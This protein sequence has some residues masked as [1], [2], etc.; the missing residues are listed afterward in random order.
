[1]DINNPKIDQDTYS[2]FKKRAQDLNFD[3]T[4]IVPMGTTVLQCS[5]FNPSTVTPVCGDVGLTVDEA[6]S[7]FDNNLTQ[8]ENG[9]RQEWMPKIEIIKE[10]Y[11]EFEYEFL[12][13]TGM[14]VRKNKNILFDVM[15]GKVDP[16]ILKKRIGEL[17]VPG[18]TE[19]PFD[20]VMPFI[21]R[22][23]AEYPI[24]KFV[25]STGVINGE[26]VLLHHIDI[27]KDGNL[28]ER[29]FTEL[30]DYDTNYLE[31]KSLLLKF[32]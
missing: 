26:D 18:T 16:D 24:Y 9:L 23:L 11:P 10:F 8:F 1:M 15:M 22:L 32:L 19:Q 4:A 7:F 31:I 6:I 13:S 20:K 17:C 30:K 2:A 14:R 29:Y 27:L 28:I 12:G 21:N 5:I 3:I 25:P